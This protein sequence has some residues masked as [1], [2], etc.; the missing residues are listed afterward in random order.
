MARNA[1]KQLGKLNRLWLQKE[2]EDGRIKDARPRPKLSSLNSSAAVK[3]WIPSIKSDMEYYLQ[4][5]Q[6]SHYP[7]RKIAEFQQHIE[8]LEKEYKR[9][10]RKLRTL[11]PSCKHHPWT[12]RA[13]SRLRQGGASRCPSGGRGCSPTPYKVQIQYDEIDLSSTE[14]RREVGVNRDLGSPQADV[15]QPPEPDG[16]RLPDLPGQD[17]PLTFDQTRLSVAVAA[18]RR[19]AALRQTDSLAQVLFTGLPN[20]QTRR[21]SQASRTEP[22][23][24]DVLGLSCYSSSDEEMSNVE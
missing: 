13:Y 18:S 19:P 12:P 10:V 8:E 6:L 21:S 23:P 15:A 22:A 11:D 24:R 16:V 17:Q 4:Q 20:L 2:R 3:R 7:E 14:E 5:S 9:F 1:E